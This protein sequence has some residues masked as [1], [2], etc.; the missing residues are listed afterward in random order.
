MNIT[1]KDF[2]NYAS[3]EDPTREDMMRC[4]LNMTS[5]QISKMKSS[6]FEDK[7]TEIESAIDIEK[8][9]QPRFTLNGVEYGFIPNLDDITYGENKDLVGYL[10]DWQTMHK[11]MA[12]AYRPIVFRKGNK[13]V[14]EEYNGT[15][16]RGDIMRD[17]PLSIVNGMT[18]F[19]YNLISD[20]LDCI[21]K[22]M[23]NQMEKHQSLLK[24]GEVIK[25]SMRSAK[26]TL[27]DS[28]K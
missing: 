5:G 19:F 8:P 21:P 2:Q 3:L 14:I 18:V 7:I 23:E 10:N 28:T 13:Y 6:E 22:F 25:K 16:D 9:F 27:Q 26:E 20:L 11:A 17:M 24:N 1:L 4:F 15:G 12:V